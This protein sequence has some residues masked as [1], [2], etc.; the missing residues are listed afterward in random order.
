MSRLTVTL[1]NAPSIKKYAAA[2]A[3]KS[4]QSCRTLC[5][6]MDC[7]LPGSSIHGIFRATV[8]ELQVNTSHVHSKLSLSK[9]PTVWLI[10][11]PPSWL[12]ESSGSCPEALQ[13]T[14][15]IPFLTSMLNLRD[16]DTKWIH[17]LHFSERVVYKHCPG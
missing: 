12:T 16:S 8:L 7:S 3:A 14:H 1:H 9:T 11:T 5:D 2:A 13:W 17:W 10:P 15:L 6:P 4:L